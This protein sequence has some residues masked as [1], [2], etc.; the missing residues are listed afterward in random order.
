MTSNTTPTPNYVWG[1][2]TT[3]YLTSDITPTPNNEVSTPL[4]H[5]RLWE[6]NETLYGTTNEML[7]GILNGM[8][9]GKDTQQDV[10]IHFSIP[11]NILFSVPLASHSILCCSGVETS[12]FGIGVKSDVIVWRQN[13]VRCHKM[14][15]IRVWHQIGVRYYRVPSNWCQSSY[16]V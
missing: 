15:V 5:R 14:S 3:P 8:L 13:G 6:A 11:F 16:Y 1:T 4:W 10:S 12:Y 7:N 9:N 2:N